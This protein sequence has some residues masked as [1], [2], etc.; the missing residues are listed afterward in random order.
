MKPCTLKIISLI[1]CG[2]LFGCIG[3]N[4]KNNTPQIYPNPYPQILNYPTPP[5]FNL[6]NF[7]V[8]NGQAVSNAN[9]D[10]STF[11]ENNLGISYSNFNSN[12]SVAAQ[13]ILT[14]ASL[15]IINT[16]KGTFVCTAVPIRQTNGYTIFITASHCF[17][18]NKD[19][20]NTLTSANVVT[21][22][23]ISIYY[24]QKPNTSSSFN[25]F[26]TASLYLPTQ[27]C[28]GVTFKN[29]D[30]CPLFYYVPGTQQNDIA[31]LVVN[32]NFG[33]P[34]D[35]PAVIPVGQY[36]Q[37]Y[38]G[39]S[40]L[41]I[42]YGAVNNAQESPVL[43]NNTPQAF[44]VSSYYYMVDDNPGY[45]HVYN[46]YFN[47]TQQGYTTLICSGDSGGPDLFWDGNK[48]NLI[49]E[50]TFGPANVCGG[51]YKNL[52]YGNVATRVGDYYDWIV[53]IE[54][55]V[56]NGDNNFCS[57]PGNNCLQIGLLQNHPQNSQ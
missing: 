37:V 49:S 27:Y 15:V 5:I 4:N 38:T 21:A 12:T 30:E 1:F 32:G 40:I 53:G 29:G 28:A 24:G 34:A 10:Y 56:T 3:G 55:S 6:P 26:T 23:N 20:P 9:I 51:F 45:H 22:Q 39:A 57:E 52:Y 17:V 41:S 16:S 47:P 2:F 50:H 13:K 54:N 48:W 33:N 43:I 14:M 44:Y 18:T 46:S 8:T 42:G 31:I 11:N 7:S 25:R 36:P 35:F 19:S